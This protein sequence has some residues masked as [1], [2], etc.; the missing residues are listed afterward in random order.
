[1]SHTLN[2]LYHANVLSIHGK[3]LGS[4]ERGT[5][6]PLFAELAA[7]GQGRLVIDLSQTDFMD[8]TG[9]GLLVNGAKTLRAAGGDVRLA[10]LQDRIKN[11]FVI[12]RL[13]GPVFKDYADVEAAV[14]S[15]GT[16]ANAGLA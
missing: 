14:Q 1:M 13:L 3:F 4:L 2:E 7:S 16:E 12:T 6:Q 9:I 10:G 8:S 11:L 15:F 5:M